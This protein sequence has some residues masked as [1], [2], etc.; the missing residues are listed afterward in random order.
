MFQISVIM[1]ATSDDDK[2]IPGFLYQ[3]ICNILSPFKY[4][5]G[6]VVQSV[7]TLTEYLGIASLIPA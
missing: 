5:L 1:K 4:Q 3:E 6:P 2:P 7:T